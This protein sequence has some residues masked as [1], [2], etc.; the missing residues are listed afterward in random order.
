MAT[1]RL[2]VGGLL[3][4]LGCAGSTGTTRATPPPAL[5]SAR[6]AV[7]LDALA[8]THDATVLVFWSAG[9]PCVRRYQARVDALLTRA[10]GRVQVVAVS[11][12]AGESFEE[13]QRVAAERGVKVPLWLDP[14]GEVA[15][16]VGARSTPT[17]VV[18]DRRGVVRFV[19]WIDNERE[20]GADDREPWLER[21]IDGVLANGAFAA[22]TPTWG[23]TITR[24]AF[25]SSPQHCS[26]P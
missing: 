25:S 9:C 15:R 2:L 1:S 22:R 4:L 18:L 23:C 5:T 7:T 13:A 19:G 11:S 24:A 3:C 6:G 20:P 21:A 17:A 26:A 16:L 10:P 14:G 8:A 12:N